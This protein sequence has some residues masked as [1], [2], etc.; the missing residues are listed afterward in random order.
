MLCR[1]VDLTASLIS[2]RCSS[3][4]RFNGFASC[5][6]P[7][8]CAAGVFVACWFCLGPSGAPKSAGAV[9]PRPRCLEKDE[10]LKGMAFALTE[11]S[12]I[13]VPAYERDA[14]GWPEAMV[15]DWARCGG[16]SCNVWG[17]SGWE[18]SGELY[19]G[20]WRGFFGRRG[21]GVETDC[22]KAIVG[23]LPENLEINMSRCHKSFE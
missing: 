8:L 16:M 4:N 23:L 12:G 17:L 13:L 19:F 10:A 18:I 1:M 6:G 14:N 7:W 9:A 21:M 2:S 11:R 20:R 5:A 3:V 22:F 15:V